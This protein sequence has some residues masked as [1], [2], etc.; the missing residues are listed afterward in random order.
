MRR[1]TVYRKAIEIM[2]QNER[3]GY[4]HWREN[5]A[6]NA[7]DTAQG[8]GLE[9]AIGY[10]DE[11]SAAAQAFYDLFTPDCIPLNVHQNGFFG[12]MCPR[13]THE[14]IIALGFMLAMVEAGDA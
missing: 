14:R 1:T 10:K 13:G 3:S 5:Y 8:W 7:I 4:V 12:P 9:P 6:C 11:R 2:E